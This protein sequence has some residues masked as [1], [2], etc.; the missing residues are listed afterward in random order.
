MRKILPVIAA[1]TFAASALS[2]CT[3][4]EKP[5]SN[6][7]AS[8]SSSTPVTESITTEAADSNNAD[9]DN[10]SSTNAAETT[11]A[12][13]A[14]DESSSLSVYFSRV[15]NTDFDDNVDA[16]S[17]ASL[18]IVNGK[19]KGNAQLIAEWIAEEA[20]CRTLEIVSSKA[21]PV[22]YNE[23]VNIANEEKNS[24]ARPELKDMPDD[25]STYDTIWLTFPNWWADLPMPVYSFFDK[26][27]LSGKKIVVFA[28]HE[29]SGFS[30]T[31]NR[32]KELE[33]DADV[34]E[35]LSVR[36]GSV[37]DKEQEIRSF[38]SENK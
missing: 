30:D 28:T 22:D 12:T 17:S 29:G 9:T 36:G 26:Y 14:K 34:V 6:T 23:T 15:G 5:Q 35:G 8:V 3:E 16:T 33:P 24:K 20:D 18:N 21:Y 25:L 4:T 7:N 38:V 32:I 10:T 2:A 27:D 1:V 11:E 13:E 37:N 31:I 19:L